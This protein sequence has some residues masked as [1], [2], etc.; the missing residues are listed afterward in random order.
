M[1]SLFAFRRTCVFAFVVRVC[2]SCPVLRGAQ[3]GSFDGA[4]RLV[5]EV[6]R[7]WPKTIIAMAA[8]KC[9]RLATGKLEEEE[10]VG[11]SGL[12]C[13]VSS[14]GKVRNG[15]QG[16]W[17]TPCA[18]SRPMYVCI[19]SPACGRRASGSLK[20]RA[21][22]TFRRPLSLATTWRRRSCRSVRVQ[23]LADRG[24]GNC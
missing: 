5:E 9:D 7:K 13:P 16:L 4:K 21:S 6:Q 3:R 2:H 24:E 12:S 14:C 10:A 22:C 20:K 19:T 11:L 23:H 15:G 1:S 18:A 17:S 8:T